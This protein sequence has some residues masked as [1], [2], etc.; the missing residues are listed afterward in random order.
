MVVIAPAPAGRRGAHGR[1]EP[2]GAAGGEVRAGVAHQLLEVLPLPDGGGDVGSEP[3]AAALETSRSSAET[4]TGPT[5]YD[6]PR[7][8][9]A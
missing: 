2:A 3:V 1:R 9:T 6:G 7:D 4:R 5:V 8:V